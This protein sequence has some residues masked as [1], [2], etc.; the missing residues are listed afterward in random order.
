MKK[1]R[2]SEGLWL[3]FHMPQNE[4]RKRARR[5]RAGVEQRVGGAAGLPSQAVWQQDSHHRQCG[6]VSGE[7]V[8]ATKLRADVAWEADIPWPQPRDIQP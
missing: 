4:G 8:K 2:K 1:Q 3:F 5:S 6:E 7:D